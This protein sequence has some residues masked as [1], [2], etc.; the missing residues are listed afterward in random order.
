L[1]GGL[2]LGKKVMIL[3][4]LVVLA[5]ASYGAYSHFATRTK[6][7][8]TVRQYN[9]TLIQ[10]MRRPEPELMKRYT[11]Q[12]EYERVSMYVVFLYG[13]NKVLDAKLTKYTVTQLTVSGS[14]AKLISDEI[15]DDRYID[16]KTGQ[17]T[18][19]KEHFHY[20]G[21]YSLEK[22]KSG[23]WVVSELNVKEL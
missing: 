2:S 17:D 22:D 21:T 3:L 6:V 9:N 20:Q 4:V 12:Q 13:K 11:T 7:Q 8:D 1:K 16:A 19:E 14:T 15:W 23:T 5:G 18:G 10:A